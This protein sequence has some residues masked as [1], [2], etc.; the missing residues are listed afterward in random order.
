VL[1][2]PVYER[3]GEL[4]RCKRHRVDFATTESCA[5]CDA[6]PGRFDPGADV[7][8]PLPTPPKGCGSS[9]DYERGLRKEVDAMRKRANEWS[10]QRK[11]KSRLA[12]ATAAKLWDTYLKGMR[13]LMDLALDRE[14]EE[15]QKARERR[16]RKRRAGVPH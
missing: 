2:D 14:H 6:D 16:D 4:L 13:L 5:R 11:V 3:V 12:S 9:L 10:E 1:T 15:I 7:E 8:E